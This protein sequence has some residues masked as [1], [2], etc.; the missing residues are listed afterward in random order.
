[1]SVWP[2]RHFVLKSNLKICHPFRT[3]QTLNGSSFSTTSKKNQ[4]EQ[5]IQRKK[6]QEANRDAGDAAPRHTVEP[7]REHSDGHF[8]HLIHSDDESDDDRN[9]S[10]SLLSAQSGD[11]LRM[12]NRIEEVCTALG[13][14]TSTDDELREMLNE[15]D[16]ASVDMSLGLTC[17]DDARPRA[18]SPEP[19]GVGERSAGG[20]KRV[21]EECIQPVLSGPSPSSFAESG[22]FDSSPGM[23][24]PADLPIRQVAARER[25]RSILTSRLGRDLDEAV[26]GSSEYDRVSAA[27]DDGERRS[28][29]VPTLD[30]I[31]RGPSDLQADVLAFCGTGD[32]ADGI[33][34]FI[35]E[36]NRLS[37]AEGAEESVEAAVG[38]LRS[39]SGSYHTKMELLGGDG[40]GDMRRAESVV[41][42]IVAQMTLHPNSVGILEDGCAI[43]GEAAEDAALVCRRGGLGVLA[44]AA[45]SGDAHLASAAL[46][47]LSAVATAATPSDLLSCGACRAVV[48]AMARHPGDAAVQ[49]WGAGAARSLSAVDDML[50]ESFVGL[51]GADLVARAMDGFVACET[52]QEKGIG[53]V[54]S[55]AV[56][57]GTKG[58]VR[59]AAVGSVTN[60]L[61]AFPG[62]CQV[63]ANGLGCLK[64]FSID[65][66]STG[67]FDEAIELVYSCEFSL[68]DIGPVFGF[69]SI[70][71][72]WC[73]QTASPLPFLQACGYT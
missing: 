48:G 33:L 46:R 49:V 45:G 65:S 22:F 39:M 55:L 36:A 69:V 63:V 43:L 3:N 51:G 52:M 20:A 28:R 58:R 35:A 67:W 47:A 42:T 23:P 29:S 61:A 37:G 16:R 4:L 41:D 57:A 18:A 59:S 24:E 13:D 21:W 53:A 31:R 70:R 56:S 34:H 68:I 11:V 73:S 1:M 14:Y 25:I 27:F 9:E 26:G 40:T 66:E 38:M 44:D 7:I 62:S 32:V 8:P 12:A 71:A 19:A 72:A 60:G 6:E 2:G 10:F 5:R 54:W 50:K 17:P 30:E 15:N 64:C